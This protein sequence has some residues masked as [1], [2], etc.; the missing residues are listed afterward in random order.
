MVAPPAAYADRARTFDGDDTDGVMDVERAAHAHRR[1]KLVHRFTT[2]GA[3][4]DDIFSPSWDPRAQV[5]WKIRGRTRSGKLRLREIVVV[6]TSKGPKAVMCVVPKDAYQC[7]GDVRD[8]VRF[9]HPREDTGKVVFPRW[10][11]G[12]K[13]VR[14]RWWLDVW[15]KSDDPNHPECPYEE[16]WRGNCLDRVGPVRHK[17][18]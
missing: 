1:S 7:E 2:V 13:V 18:R 14:Y 5:S 10:W 9:R 6:G 3:W 17:L 15:W 8:A 12:R 4:S 11:L 16:S